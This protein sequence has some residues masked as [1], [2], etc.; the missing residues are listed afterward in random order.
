MRGRASKWP[1]DKH[2]TK[3]R[4]DWC[5]RSVSAL[6]AHALRKAVKTLRERIVRHDAVAQ[7]VGGQRVPRRV[8]K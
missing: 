6:Q 3:I 2:G 1:L 5:T 8:A 7:D 4:Q